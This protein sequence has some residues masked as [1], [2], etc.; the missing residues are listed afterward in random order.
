M[1]VVAAVMEAREVWEKKAEPANFFEFVTA[2]EHAGED[3]RLGPPPCPLSLHVCMYVCVCIRLGQD[4][5]TKNN[6]SSICQLC[7][8]NFGLTNRR[9][10][11]RCGSECITLY[12]MH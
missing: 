3:L 1:W 11:C 8:A 6:N 4:A 2:R 7:S 12:G 10:H 9:H 5:W